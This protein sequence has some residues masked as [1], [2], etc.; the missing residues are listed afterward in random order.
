MLGRKTKQEVVSEFRCAEILRAAGKVFARTGF[1]AATVDEIAAAAGLAKATLYAYFP[2]KRDLYL[3]AVKREIGQLI[4]LARR[5]IEAAPT[6]PEKIRAFIAAL[7]RFAEQNRDGLALFFA[8]PASL[9]PGCF[10]KELKHLHAQQ[11][12][13]LEAVLQQGARE[14]SIRP[15]DA[16]EVAFLIY[17]LTRAWVAHRRLGWSKSSAEEGI[18]CLFDLLWDGL[19]VSRDPANREEEACIRSC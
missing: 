2:S 8:E 11:T 16:A 18:Q 7:V 17:D 10:H 13:L 6:T 1:E 3:G 4:S 15:V 12:R 5:G 19:S 14:G 9:L